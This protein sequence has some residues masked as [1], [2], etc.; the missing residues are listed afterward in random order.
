MIWP[1][2]K[3]RPVGEF[4][5]FDLGWIS[6]IFAACD[7]IQVDRGKLF[8]VCRPHNDFEIF[9]HL[10]DIIRRWDAMCLEAQRKYPSP[11]SSRHS[12][13]ETEGYQKV[14]VRNFLTKPVASSNSSLAQAD[15]MAR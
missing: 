1:G 4:L 3:P 5:I 6:L 14:L 12:M 15:S 10:D 9:R 8:D 2:K 13:P 7:H 11:N